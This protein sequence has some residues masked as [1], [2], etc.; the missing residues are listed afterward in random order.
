[1]ATPLQ[2]K[3]NIFYTFLIT[4]IFLN[5]GTKNYSNAERTPG[6]GSID[7]KAV[8]PEDDICMS[9]F[10]IPFWNIIPLMGNVGKDKA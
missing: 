8:F 1:M 4:D 6:G 5:F 3:W 7:V 2:G 9:M 10:C